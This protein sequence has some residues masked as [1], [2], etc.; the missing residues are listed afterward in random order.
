MF[1]H[2]FKF[3][4][5]LAVVS[6]LAACTITFTPPYP[7]SDLAAN[8]LL[9]IAVDSQGSKHIVGEDPNTGQLVYLL[10]RLG[11]VEEKVP[12]RLITDWWPTAPDIGVLDDGTVIIGWYEKNDTGASPKYR[13]CLMIYPSMIGVVCSADF[14]DSPPNSFTPVVQI[15]TRGS[16][17][18]I[19]YS[20]QEGTQYTLLYEKIADVITSGKVNWSVSDPMV[21]TVNSVV[22]SAGYLHV[23]WYAKNDG[24]SGRVLYASNRTTDASGNMTQNRILLIADSDPVNPP[25]IAAYSTAGGERVAFAY[26]KDNSGSDDE[27]YHQN[28]KVDNTDWS[29][30]QKLNLTGGAYRLMDVHLVG[31]NNAYLIGFLRNNTIST[32][33]EVWLRDAMGV[34]TQITS[35]TYAERELEMVPAGGAFVMAYKS[36]QSGGPREVYIYDPLNGERSVYSEL[37]ASDNL[38]GEMAVSGDVVAG[39]W[40]QCDRAW[41]STNAEL[42][43]LPLVKKE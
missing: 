5:L 1:K 2:L 13:F 20:K 9:A 22:D 8:H 42:V 18:Y 21:R 37:C 38:G 27:I 15:T 6:L 40:A 19:I 11:P 17:A 35:N 10:T 34:I 41:F 43:Y 30:E 28:I 4:M 24:S 23:V 36:V 39:V 16:I 29:G 14:S 32:T 25:A 33:S 26:V 12:I 31:V 3:G 7:L